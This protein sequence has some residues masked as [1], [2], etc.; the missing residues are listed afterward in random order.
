MR[1]SFIRY[2]RAEI[3]IGIVV[4]AVC[5]GLFL[6]GNHGPVVIGIGA[7]AAVIVAGDRF[8]RRGRL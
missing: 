8:V 4:V 5:V 7:V 2:L 3:T 1:P 6:A